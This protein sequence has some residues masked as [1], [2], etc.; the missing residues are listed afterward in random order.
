MRFDK[1]FTLDGGWEDSCNYA[2]KPH[3]ESIGGAGL[4][5]ETAPGTNAPSGADAGMCTFT[6][7]NRAAH[8]K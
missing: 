6:A 8:C 1:P 2:V 7:L 4:M 3:G 5:Y